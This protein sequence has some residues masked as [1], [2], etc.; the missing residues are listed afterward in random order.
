MN[1]FAKGFFKRADRDDEQAITEV[2]ESE[3]ACKRVAMVY[4]KYVFDW[5]GRKFFLLTNRM[6]S[7]IREK[8]LSQ[9]RKLIRIAAD[10]GVSPEIYIKAQFEQ[11]MPWLKT[12]SLK[13]VPFANLISQKAITR[14]KEYKERIDSSYIEKSEQ[15]K[16]FYSTLSLQIRKAIQDSIKKF[17]ERLERM[18]QP[19]GELDE[20]VVL[21]ELEI[22]TRSGMLSNIYIYS[23]P[24]VDSCG[25]EYLIGLKSKVDKKLNEFEKKQILEVRR[26]SLK[27]FED[28][29]LK[30]YV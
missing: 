11:Q 10:I 1:E 12:K 14:F 2:L 17:Y 6:G 21:S 13:Y 28:E 9:I 4:G 26:E 29:D 18:K 30:R 24:I 16:E 7:E 15:R 27:E 25:S 19:T 22:M 5:S 3:E 23:M 20:A 8:R